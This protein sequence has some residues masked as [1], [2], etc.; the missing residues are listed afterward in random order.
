[1]CEACIK[2]VQLAPQDDN[3]QGRKTRAVAEK[4]WSG[5]SGA[6]WRHCVVA[7]VVEMEMLAYFP[8]LFVI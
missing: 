8:P 2:N 6:C 7:S 4:A 5:Y 1:M 3:G